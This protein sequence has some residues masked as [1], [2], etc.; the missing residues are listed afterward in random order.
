MKL[1]LCSD[2]SGVGFRFLDKFFPETQGLNCLF[3]GYAND[4]EFELESD[5]CFF[6]KRRV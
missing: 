4:D 5:E 1:L 2:F 3:V 6:I